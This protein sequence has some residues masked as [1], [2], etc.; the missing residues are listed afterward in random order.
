MALGN[1]KPIAPG[2]DELLGLHVLH[3]GCPVG[4]IETSV[5]YQ[6]GYHVAKLSDDGDQHH[7]VTCID[8]T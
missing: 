8:I 4:P 6:L 7:H 3:E 5:P 2:P 1:G